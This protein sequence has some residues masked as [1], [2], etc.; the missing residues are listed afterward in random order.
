MSVNALQGKFLSHPD[1]LTHYTDLRGMM[2]IIES[3]QI[4]ASNV[5]FLND[6]RELLHGLP[7]TRLVPNRSNP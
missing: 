5:S 7:M 4:W 1:S 6:R 3:K 2:G